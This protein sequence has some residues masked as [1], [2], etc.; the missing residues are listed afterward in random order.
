[1]VLMLTLGIFFLLFVLSNSSVMMLVLSYN[2]FVIFYYYLL[3]ACLFFNK[4]H[5]GSGWRQEGNWEESGR[6]RW[7]GNINPDILCEKNYT[8]I[9]MCERP[10]LPQS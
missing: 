2:F 5:K 9:Y 10:G 3:E 7:R 8:C 1:M 6:R 4:S